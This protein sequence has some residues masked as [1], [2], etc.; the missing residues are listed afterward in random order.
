MTPPPDPSPWMS[1]YYALEWLIRL[2]MLAIVPL[3]RT[4]AAARS[5]LL[6]AFFLPLLGL[7]LFLLIGRPSFPRWRRRRFRRLSPRIARVAEALRARGEAGDAATAALVE[8]IGGFPAV[9]GHVVDLVDDYDAV[10]DRLVA[11]IDAARTHVRLLAYIF[12]DD[13]SGQRVIH[14][15]ARAVRR[16]VAC[17]VLFDPVGSRPWARSVRRRLREAGVDAR[18]ALPFRLVRGRTRRDMRNHRKLFLVDG[19]VAWAGSQNLVDRDFREGVV[20]HEL[21]ARITGPTVAALEAVF[22]L[23][24]ALETRR[25]LPLAAVPEATGSA[26]LQALPSGADYAMQGFLTLLAWRIHAATREVVIVTPYLVPDES[27]SGAL[28]TA[29]LR[30]VDVHLV[31][32]G[33]V[34][35]WLVNLAQRSYYDDLLACGVRIHRFRGGLLHAKNAT[36]DGRFGLLGSSNVDIRSFQLNEEIS[37]LLHDADCAAQ[38]RAIQQRWMDASDVLDLAAWRARPRLPRVAENAARMVSPLL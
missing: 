26:V 17:H 7:A 11:D 25:L 30:G 27:L 29:A 34:D 4:P 35:Q 36:I 15:L 14:A 21:V 9:G 5:W 24:W 10:I 37:L 18:A 19:A 31:L 2:A 28:R 20:N 32:S 3:R 12:A 1:A 33:V 6:L 16:G 23:D 22:A 8:R 13:D 38:L